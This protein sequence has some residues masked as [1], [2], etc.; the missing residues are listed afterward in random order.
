MFRVCLYV[1]H[2]RNDIQKTISCILQFALIQ[3][4]KAVILFVAGSAAALADAFQLRKCR[5]ALPER[6]QMHGVRKM[7]TCPGFT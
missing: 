3:C 4:E 1:C 5:P 7:K 6:M 2:T